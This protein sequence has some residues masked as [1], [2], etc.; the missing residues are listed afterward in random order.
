MKILVVA[1]KVQKYVY[2]PGLKERMPDVEL[3]LSCGDL[4]FYYLEFI[5]SCL[6][7]PLFYVFGNHNTFE[8]TRSEPEHELPDLPGGLVRRIQRPGRHIKRAPEGCVNVDERVVQHKGLLIGGLEGSMRYKPH[9]PYQYTDGQMRLK[10]ARMSFRLGLARIRW[11][12]PLDILITHAPAHNI[13]DGKDLPHRGFK[14]LLSFMERFQPRYLIHGHRHVYHLQR[15]EV[16]QY[17][18]TTVMNVYGHSVMDV[19]PHL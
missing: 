19:E 4:P 15:P 10:V 3:V 17:Q 11:G 12:R 7:V 14:A 9:A 18:E 1:D 5:V 2:S 16:T 6:N 8:Y 13:H